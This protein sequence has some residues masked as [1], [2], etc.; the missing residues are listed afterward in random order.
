M[1]RVDA[2]SKLRSENRS[3][4]ASRIARLVSR[5]ATRDTV[6]VVTIGVLSFDQTLSRFADRTISQVLGAS[7][8]LQRRLRPASR[9]IVPVDQVPEGR[10]VVGLDVLVLQVEGV[11]PRVDHEQGHGT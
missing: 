10:D 7:N 5:P 8:R 11:L 9:D 3:S 2:P 6:S 1:A 4:A